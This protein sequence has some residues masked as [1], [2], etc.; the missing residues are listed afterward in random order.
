MPRV[1]THPTSATQS[2]ASTSVPQHPYMIKSTRIAN[3][4]KVRMGRGA[5][6]SKFPTRTYHLLICLLGYLRKLRYPP[7]PFMPC[8]YLPPSV[9]ISQYPP[10]LAFTILG[11][12]DQVIC[13]KL[14]SPSR[15]S[16]SFIFYRNCPRCSVLPG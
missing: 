3:Q 16:S 13:I 1:R 14:R 10:Y 5:K 2:N 11:I 15:H 12:T 9:G 8:K 6:E 4:K 7:S